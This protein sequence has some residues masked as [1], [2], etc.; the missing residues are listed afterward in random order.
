MTALPQQRSSHRVFVR[1]T[2]ALLVVTAAA[3]AGVAAWRRGPVVES[4]GD[5]PG[6]TGDEALDRLRAYL[7]QAHGLRVLV[8]GKRAA[9]A[10]NEGFALAR[11]GFFDNLRAHTFT[12]TAAPAGGGAP[13]VFRA[14]A[15]VGASGTPI[16]V[17]GLV[18]LT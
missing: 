11:H 16:E 15:R 9:I 4:G 10:W 3:S 6:R 5:L 17:T 13:D 8:E 12:F 1:V 2:L 14:R 7:L 18:N